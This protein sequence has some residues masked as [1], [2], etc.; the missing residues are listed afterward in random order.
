MSFN[1]ENFL[2]PA[3]LHAIKRAGLHK[4]A[5]AM[6][7]LN[8]LTIK[9]AVAL[10]GA[11]AHMRRVEGQKIAMGIQALARLNGEKNA[12]PDPSLWRTL[13]PRAVGPG[14]IGAGIAAAP[15]LLRDGPVDENALLQRA[16]LG[17][18]IGGVSGMGAALNRGL[19]TNPGIES[20]MAEA[21]QRAHP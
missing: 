1:V 17:G 4:I 15:E 8:E 21:V 16:L 9:E 11:K 20:Q 19:R 13:L 18:T 2:S 6:V 14:L 10:V 12:A 5:G 7:D 3:A